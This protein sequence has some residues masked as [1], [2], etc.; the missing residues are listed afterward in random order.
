M[1]KVGLLKI[2]IPWHALMSQPVRVILRDVYVSIFSRASFVPPAPTCA[3]PL[4]NLTV[5]HTLTH[6]LLL[7]FRLLLR[8][9]R[10]WHCGIRALARARS[11]AWNRYVVVCPREEE[12]KASV[13]AAD[14]EAELKKQKEA[15][16]ANWELITFPEKVAP[17]FFARV[18]LPPLASLSKF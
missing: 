14:I 10:A 18:T 15:A 8:A 3:S 4:R 6:P 17:F 7:C 16:L 13:S 2:V 11:F 12:A 5:A 1:G 9:R